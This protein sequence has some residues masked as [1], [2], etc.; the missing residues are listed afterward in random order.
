MSADLTMR[1]MDFLDK[2][3]TA[4][5]A[6][7]SA[8]TMLEKK[9]FKRF[10]ERKGWILP[11]GTKGYVVRDDSSIIA[12][13]MGRHS[14]A[15]DGFRIV[16]AHTDVPGLRVKPCGAYKKEGYKLLGVEIYGGP[17]LASWLDRDLTLAGRVFLKNN[18]GSAPQ[19]RLFN[20]EKP[21]CR[22]PQ[23][24]IHLNRGVNDD[25]LKLNKQTHLPPLCGIDDGEPFE[26]EKIRDR[27]ADLAGCSADDIVDFRLEAVDTQKAA[28]CGFDGDFYASGRIDNL[29]G[30]FTSLM[31]FLA[32]SDTPDA[33]QVLALFD[34]EEIGS[35]TLNGASSNFIDSILERLAGNRENFMRALAGSIIISNDGAHAVHPNYAELHEPKHKPVLNGGPVLKMN[36]SERYITQSAGAPYFINLCRL[37]NVP[38]QRI[39]VRS[40]LPCGSTIGPIISSRLGVMG[41]DIGLPMLSMHSI[42]ETGGTKDAE[43]MIK[44]LAAHFG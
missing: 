24:A 32:A 27:I 14:P 9:G 31:A 25:G 33:T 1:L 18:N 28:L 37:H 39:V 38:L 10:F 19:T 12:F 8:M 34:S 13:R 5:H 23:L 15:E 40:D 26:M 22:I 42:R 3:V 35:A 20:F 6:A 41:A 29:G 44:A 36:S 21:L 4:S 7:A 43:L 2:G 17:I 11:I 30:S 16:G